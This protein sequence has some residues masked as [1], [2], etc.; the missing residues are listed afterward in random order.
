MAPVLLF[1]SGPKLKYESD[2]EEEGGEKLK[3]DQCLYETS[4][5]RNLKRHIKY[6]HAPTDKIFKCEQCPYTTKRPNALRTHVKGV[7]AKEGD[8]VYQCDRC[9]YSTVFR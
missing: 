5:L 7:H 9:S 1:R 2:Q 4:K 8:K 6:S 3:C